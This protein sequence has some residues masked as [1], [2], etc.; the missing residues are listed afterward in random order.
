MNKCS[1]QELV[2]YYSYLCYP[3]SPLP[4]RMIS[5]KQTMT[6]KVH[7]DNQNVMRCSALYVDHLV[8]PPTTMQD[9][10]RSHNVQGLAKKSSLYNDG[11]QF[12]GL[13]YLRSNLYSNPMVNITIIKDQM[14]IGANN[15]YNQRSKGR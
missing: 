3:I 11:G 7:A 14:W 15:H 4:V 1:Y 5:I 9:E 6:D 8:P 12:S 2:F 10:N 13:K